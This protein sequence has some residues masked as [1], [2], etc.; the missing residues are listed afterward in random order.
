[1]KKYVIT[2]LYVLF[3]SITQAQWV[4]EGPTPYSFKE[5]Y[6]SGNDIVYLIHNKDTVMIKK[7]NGPYQIFTQKQGT[8]TVFLRNSLVGYRC[9]FTAGVGGTLEMT[10]DGG[11]NWVEVYHSKSFS[12][13]Y[14]SMYCIND[15]TCYFLSC[16]F[17]DSCRNQTGYDSKLIVSKYEN[18][19]LRE[20]F[21]DCTMMYTLGK[22]YFANNSI[23]F[24]TSYFSDSLGVQHPYELRRTTDGGITWQIVDFWSKY[25][26][27]VPQIALIVSGLNNIVAIHGKK[28]DYLSLDW[29]KTWDRRCDGFEFYTF[30]DSLR[31]WGGRKNIQDT[32]YYSKDR[33]INWYLVP[34]IQIWNPDAISCPKNDVCYI[35]HSYNNQPDQFYYYVVHNPIS[36]VKDNALKINEK[37]RIVVSANN[38]NLTFELRESINENVVFSLYNIDGRLVLTDKLKSG[39]DGYIQYNLPVNDFVKGVYIASFRFQ[40]ECIT[41]KIIIP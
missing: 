40:N 31:V 8:Q 37:N 12:A 41:K 28:C 34:T 36:S 21:S 11:Y 18:G 23:G 24:F 25:D 15:T 39:K 27:V 38:N 10:K 14:I 5:I 2:L 32:L 22:I 9:G 30:L 29:G 19:K 7:G 17:N 6:G 3:Y 26:S 13:T 1:M 20:V 33:G 16:N 35:F 4:L